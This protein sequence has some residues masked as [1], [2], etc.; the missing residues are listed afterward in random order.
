MLLA[1][2][3]D[4]ELTRTDADRAT[5]HGLRA[6]RARPGLR[7]RLAG[8]AVGHREE[9]AGA[10]DRVA[11][12]VERLQ[13]RRRDQPAHAASTSTATGRSRSCSTSSPRSSS[14]SPAS[15]RSS[16]RLWVIGGIAIAWAAVQ[17]ALTPLLRQ[18]SP[19]G[20][21]R[22]L[23]WRG[24]RNYLR[25][26]SQLADAPVGHLV[27]W[28]RYL[29]YADRARRERGARPGPRRAPAARGADDVRALVH[30]ARS[31]QHRV[32]R[33]DRELRVRARRVDRV[34]LAAVEQLGRW[35]RVLRRRW[36]RRRRRRDRRR[37]TSLRLGPSGRPPGRVHSAGGPQARAR[38][39]ASSGQQR[40][41]EVGRR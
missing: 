7:R 35:R 26:F 3:V 41:R 21:V 15:A 9:R 40:R 11:Q 34:V 37:L 13:G 33:L 38:R 28:E 29:V 30:R 24:V 20:Q 31:R 1:D 19:E 10:P 18:R 4:Y 22:F 12:P 14:A 17:I 36:R 32:V 25:D 39:V 8:H 6:Q 16:L 2:K 23:Q 27:L 5:A